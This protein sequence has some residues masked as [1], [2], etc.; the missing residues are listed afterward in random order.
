MEKLPKRRE[1]V[2]DGSMPQS[3]SFSP[4][5]DALFQGPKRFSSEF[6]RRLRAAS[7]SSWPTLRNS[8]VLCCWKQV[9]QMDSSCLCSQLTLIYLCVYLFVCVHVF[10]C[11]CMYVYTCVYICICVCVCMFACVCRCVRVYVC[12][13]SLTCGDQRTARGTWLS[14]PTTWVPGVRGNCQTWLQ[15]SYSL[16][17]IAGSLIFISFSDI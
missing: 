1:E 5:N 17:H 15:A 6:R 11:A 3:P 10:V 7:S 13:P 16:N 14:P 4:H 8:S 9:T 2:A 12:V